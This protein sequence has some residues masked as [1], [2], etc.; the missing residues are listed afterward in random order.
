MSAIVPIVWATSRLRF[1]SSI[2]RGVFC[3]SSPKAI[4]R[5]NFGSGVLLILVVGLVIPFT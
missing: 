4:A 2:A 5:L 3:I 1:S